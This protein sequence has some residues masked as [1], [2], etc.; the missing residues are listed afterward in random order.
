MSDLRY[1]ITAKTKG[2]NPKVMFLSNTGRWLFQ[3]NEPLIRGLILSEAYAKDQPTNCLLVEANEA[4]RSELRERA[5]IGIRLFC[6]D[7]EE[8][9]KK[10][11]CHAVSTKQKKEK[12]AKE[13]VRKYVLY[14]DSLAVLGQFYYSCCGGETGDKNKACLMTLAEAEVKLKELEGDGK[15]LWQ[16]KKQRAKTESCQPTQDAPIEQPQKRVGYVL[17]KE[18]FD[19]KKIYKCDTDTPLCA[20]IRIGDDA[21]DVFFAKFMADSFNRRFVNYGLRGYFEYPWKVEQIEF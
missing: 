21:A 16:L 15:Y 17:Y 1:F 9:I 8:L 12:P 5:E 19:G 3:A 7:F 18:G 6:I 13:D 11:N 20:R 2:S 14:R 4:M 10:H